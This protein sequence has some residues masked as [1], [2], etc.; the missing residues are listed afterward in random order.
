MWLVLVCRPL[1]QLPDSHTPPE[2][3]NAFGHLR[4]L[5]LPSALVLPGRWATYQSARF[6]ALSETRLSIQAVFTSGK[7][8]ACPE[9][10]TE[11]CDAR[12]LVYK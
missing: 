10:T 11:A 2:Y 1:E 4:N 8:N 7:R 6:F 5:S 12:Y 3:G 9:T